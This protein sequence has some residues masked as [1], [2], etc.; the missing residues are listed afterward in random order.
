MASSATARTSRNPVLVIV[1]V[2]VAAGL[3]AGLVYL[4]RPVSKSAATPPASSAAKAYLPYLALSGV[5]MQATENFMKQQVVEVTGNISN[6]G[7]RE[8]DSVEV[9]CI[10]YGVDGREIHRERQFIVNPQS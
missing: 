7:S 5:N 2:I 4:A 9:Y 8:L 1:C 3:I 6:N 10:F